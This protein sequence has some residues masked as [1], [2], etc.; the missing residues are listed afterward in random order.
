MAVERPFPGQEVDSSV[1][2]MT[3][4]PHS[5]D[6]LQALTM[7]LDSVPSGDKS[8]VTLPGITLC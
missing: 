1:S 6:F 5:C 7:K 2:D 4:M 3:E 8:V